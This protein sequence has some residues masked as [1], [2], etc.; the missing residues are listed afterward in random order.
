MPISVQIKAL[1]RARLVNA[2]GIMPILYPSYR[3]MKAFLTFKSSKRSF[4]LVITE[5][6]E[7]TAVGP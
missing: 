1:L 2:T 6:V 3:M 4:D 7:I 5:Y